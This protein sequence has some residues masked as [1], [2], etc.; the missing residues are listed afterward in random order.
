MCEHCDHEA[1]AARPIVDKLLKHVKGVMAECDSDMSPNRH[2][3]GCANAIV[4]MHSGDSGFIT[5]DAV[6]AMSV[7]YATVVMRLLALQQLSGIATDA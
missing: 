3:I 5:G 1:D 2:I 7:E 4:Y 6:N